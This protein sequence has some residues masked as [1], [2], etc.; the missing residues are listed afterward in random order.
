MTPRPFD[1]LYCFCLAA[2]RRAVAAAGIDVAPAGID[3]AAAGIDDIT[4]CFAELASLIFTD[5]FFD[6]F[7]RHDSTSNLYT[8]SRTCI[9]RLIIIQTKLHAQPA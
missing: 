3:V 8:K 6:I 5:F 1:R 9:V 7:I 4:A 2:T